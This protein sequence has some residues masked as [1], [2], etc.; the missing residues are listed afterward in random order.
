MFNPQLT[1]DVLM[2]NDTSLAEYYVMVAVAYGIF[3]SP[4]KLARQSFK[5]ADGDPRGTLP[6]QKHLEAVS[7]CIEKKWLEIVSLERQRGD[8]ILEIGTVDFTPE[9]FALYRR[10][11]NKIFGE[12]F[13]I[14]YEDL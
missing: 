3:L 1:F 14:G 8:D 5:L 12:D 11:T 4:E 13:V 2:E 7:R 6:E 10:I 9:G